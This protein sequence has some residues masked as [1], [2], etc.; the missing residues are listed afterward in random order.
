MTSTRSSTITVSVVIPVY[1]GRKTLPML[2]EELAELRSSST[3]NGRRFEITE[4]ILVWDHGPD[5]SDQTIRE[6]AD[7][8]EWVRPLWLSR[9]FGQHPATIAGMAATGSDWIVTMDEDGQHDPAKIADL[10]DAAF[11][12]RASLVYAAPSN[13][14][15][16]SWFRNMASRLVKNVAARA[17]T[18]GSISHFHSFRLIAGDAGRAI[19]AYAGPQTFLDVAL[20]WVSPTSVTAPVAMRAEGRE[21]S[22]YNLRR[23]LSHFWRLVISSGNRPLRLVSGFGALCAILGVFYALIVVVQYFAGDIPVAGWT[24][25]TVA[26]LVLGGVM[27][28]ALG[29][30]AEYVGLAANAAIGRP[31]YVVLED[32]KQR[33]LRDGL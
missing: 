11:T 17:L 26:T 19:A 30:I 21:A 28:T 1:A 29:V 13:P 20:S 16:H 12:D 33:F 3:P 5:E 24:T 15:P 22:N 32:P 2:V 23:L 6:L 27:L 4:V 14:P 7:R 8:H 10:I 9:N 18:G 31:L 25:V